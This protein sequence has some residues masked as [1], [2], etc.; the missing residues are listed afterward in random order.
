[1]FN[2]FL[3]FREMQPWAQLLANTGKE[4]IPAHE[5][6]ERAKDAS[7]TQEGQEGLVRTATTEEAR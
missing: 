2:L 1:M 4:L 5:D 3:C 7:V 6:S